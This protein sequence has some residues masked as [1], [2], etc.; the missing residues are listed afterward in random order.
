MTTLL[1]YAPFYTKYHKNKLTQY[2]QMAAL[3]VLFFAACIFLGLWHVGLTGLFKISLAEIATVALLVSYFRLHKG[4]S[5]AIAP[6]LVLLLW[7]AR[8]TGSSGLSSG[9]IWCFFIVALSGVLLLIISYFIEGKWPPL[10]EVSRF[11]W[12]M[13]LFLV[14]ELF[15]ATGRMT[16]LQKDIYETEESEQEKNKP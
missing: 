3:S 10:A 5:V 4:L 1:E 7:L 13:P 9:V 15:F 8:W 16:D 6:L 12:V 11:T 14:A 2:I